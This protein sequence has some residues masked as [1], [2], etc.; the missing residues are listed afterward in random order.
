MKKYD[1]IEGV[2]MA[3]IVLVHGI[4]QEQSS[5]D[6]LE[7][8]WLPALA[9]GIRTAGFPDLAD[10]VWRDAHGP[11]GID[12]RMAFYGHLFLV[13]GQQGLAEAAE[14][15]AE[16][17][18]LA[19]ALATEWLQRAA[20]QAT[21]ESVRNE[22]T[23]EL[24]YITRS[25]GVE[26]GA[27]TVVRSAVNSL[28]KISWFAPY[29]FGAAE[30]FVKRALR[31]VTFYFTREEIRAAAVDAVTKL[32]GPETKVIIGHSLG[33]VVAYESAHRLQ[34]SLPLL[35]TLGSPLGLQTIVYQRLRPQPPFFPPRVKR[36]VNIADRDDF[37]AAAPDLKPLFGV[38]VPAGAV[39]NGSYSVDNGA[40][41]HDACFYLN[42]AQTGRPIGEIFEGLGC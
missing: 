31:Q 17:S 19:E 33:S 7:S 14:V 5:A 9:G 12:V 35:V 23:Q 8:A 2:R 36:W 15:S 18:K 21:K 42:K 26:Q 38:S 27:G 37:I 39:F 20:L 24:A 32:I 13:P 34:Q 29:G 40:N 16:E 10:R 1:G 41:P 3:E 4:A 6:A 11:N 25:M 22:A 28:A 30:R